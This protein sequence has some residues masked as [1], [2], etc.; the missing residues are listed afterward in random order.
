MSGGRIYN[1]ASNLY[2]TVGEPTSG[3]KW[4]SA[5]GKTG[6]I[7]YDNTYPKIVLD[8][9]PKG[10]FIDVTMM[11]NIVFLTKTGYDGTGLFVYHSLASAVAHHTVWGLFGNMSDNATGTLYLPH[12]R[13]GDGTNTYKAISDTQWEIN[14]PYQFCGVKDKDKIYL[15]VNGI[16]KASESCFAGAVYN[17]ANWRLSFI[18]WLNI[19]YSTNALVECAYLYNRALSAQEI[20]SL[21]IDPY[22]MFRPSLPVWQMYQAPAGGLGKSLIGGNLVNNGYLIDGSIIRC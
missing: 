13:V 20:Q 15:Y 22:Q 18:E 9:N 6:F 16:L 11:V 14:T 7:H 10:N 21:Y 19:A 2:P 5:S 3:F 17:S 4:G 1:A 12:F 8:Y